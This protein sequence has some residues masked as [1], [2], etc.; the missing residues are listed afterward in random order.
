MVLVLLMWIIYKKYA[1]LS[2]THTKVF[3]LALVQ[4]KSDIQKHKK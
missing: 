4:K 3:S 1:C 2:K